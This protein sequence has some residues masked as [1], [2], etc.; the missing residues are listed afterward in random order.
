M[1]LN[2]LVIY[3]SFAAISRKSRESAPPRGEREYPVEDYPIPTTSPILD[4]WP[5]IPQALTWTRR[6]VLETGWL[7]E[8]VSEE[9]SGYAVLNRCFPAK[10][11]LLP[12][13]V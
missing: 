5:L 2:V 8:D 10:A 12:W 1:C 11:D 13:T 7:V 9:R 3:M 6:G 4:P